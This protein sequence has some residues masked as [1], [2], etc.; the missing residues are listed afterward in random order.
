M[1][2]STLFLIFLYIHI[3]KVIFSIECRK[4]GFCCEYHGGV[5]GLGLYK[6][7]LRKFKNSNKQKRPSSV[8]NTDFGIETPC[9]A[10]SG[11]SH[12]K[13]QN[14][15]LCYFHFRNNG[16]SSTR[17]HFLSPFIETHLKIMIKNRNQR[18]QHLFDG[19]SCTK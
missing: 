9:A 17:Q 12:E 10:G 8:L 14:S 16:Y 18:S 5:L 2:F 7:L 11:R 1:L 19:G 3:S 6:V 13:Q 4:Q 15:G